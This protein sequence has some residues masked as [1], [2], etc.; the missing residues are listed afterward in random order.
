MDFSYRK[1]SIL[2]ITVLLIAFTVPMAAAANIEKA[3]SIQSPSKLVSRQY[4]II[5]VQSELSS[6]LHPNQK[7]YVS[8]LPSLIN[9]YGNLTHTVNDDNDYAQ[10]VTPQAVAPI[11]ECLQKVTDGLPYSNELFADSVLAMVH[12]VPY[13]VTEVK[14]PVETLVDNYGDCVGLSLLAASIME[15]DGLNVVL[16]LYT[17][18]NPQHMNVGVYLPYTPVY[19]TPLMAPTSFTYDNKTYWTAECTPAGNWKVGDQSPSLAGAKAIIIPLSNTTQSLPLAQ[20]SASLNTN[21]LPSIITINPSQPAS[22]TEVNG[23]RALTISGSISPAIP[24]Q[25]VN[26]YISGDN[27]EASNYD[28]YA[29]YSYA[30]GGIEYLTTVTDKDGNYNST[31]NFTASGTYYITASWNGASNYSGADSQTLPVFVGPQSYFQFEAMN[32]NYIYGQPSMAALATAPMQGATDF[33]TLPLGANVSLSYNFIVLQA[34]Q[35]ISNVQTTNVTIPAS[36]ERILTPNGRIKTINV[37]AYNETV[38]LSVPNGLAPLR[39]PDD[40]NQTIDNQFCFILQNN[41]DNYCLNIK[42]LSD[43]EISGMQ[44]NAAITNATGNIKE[45]TWYKM[46]TN[47]TDNTATTNLSDVNGTLIEITSNSNSSNQTVLL[48]T[49]NEDTAIALKNLTIQTQTT[50]TTSPQQPQTTQK[51]ASNHGNLSIALSVVV[52][53]LV[54]ATVTATLYV[55]KQRKH[56]K[57]TENDS[58]QIMKQVRVPQKLFP[59]LAWVL[60]VMDL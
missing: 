43:D 3:Y 28:S 6:L 9:Y 54:A 41:A 16:I 7:L 24:G 2:L 18:V 52:S 58:V 42:G 20:V 31:W 40:F 11:A 50:S 4:G 13:N 22:S 26:I 39:L 15:A 38:P 23:E 60:V 47:I 12:Q 5:N 51:P 33:L 27:V 49:N 32:Y 34:G 21:L 44:A 35:T 48:I 36:Q 14:Y 19:H 29:Y 37:P 1:A 55:R 57:Q 17:S 53:I 8:V 59:L 45:D 46:T 10:F 56:Q 25:T 30:S